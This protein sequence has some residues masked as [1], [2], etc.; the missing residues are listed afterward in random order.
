MIGPT[1]KF[2]VEFA[3]L[4]ARWAVWAEAE[5]TGCEGVA[6]TAPS[7]SPHSARHLEALARTEY[8]L[9]GEFRVA[10]D[11][12]R[13]GE[14]QL[15]ARKGRML[16][17]LL[18]VER[19]RFVPID[20]IVAALWGDSPPAKAPQN[21]ASLVSRLRSVLGPRTIHG[22]RGGY[23]LDPADA[24]VDV[25]RAAALVDEADARLAA[26]QASLAYSAADAALGLLAAGPL[27]ADEPDALWA[28]EARREVERLG[29][30]ARRA[31]WRAALEL[32]DHQEALD[33][34]G[35]GTV[36]DPLDEEAHRA[37]MLAHHRAGEPGAALAAYSRLRETL[38]EELG[39]DPGPETE[40]LYLDILRGERERPALEVTARSAMPPEP[41]EPGFVGRDD[42]LAE[43][44]GAWEGAAR[45]QPGLWLAAGEAGIGKT[46]LA[47]E[48]AR[49]VEATGGLLAHARC[50][51]AERSL[52]LQPILDAIGTLAGALPPDVLRTAAEGSAGTLGELVP[53]V[54]RI[55]R[56]LHYE[57]GAPELERRRSFE[58]VASLLQRLARR[59]PVLLLL[60]DLH[61]AG[62]STLEALH[63]LFR[64]MAT[65]RFLA[66]ATVRAEESGEVLGQLGEL[67]RVI[68]LG[69]LTETAV[70]ELARAM[71]APGMAA[72]VARMTGGHTLYAVEALRAVVEA[73]AGERLPRVPE[74]LRA[75][76]LTRVRRAGP[77]VEEL[78]RAAAV[79]GSAF[80]VEVVAGLLG[81]PLEDAV[82]RAEH[83]L[84]ARLVV[85]AGRVYEFANDLV[86]EVLYET[87]PA[88]TRLVRHRRAIALVANP[89]AVG[90][91]AAAAGD[92]ATAMRSWEEAAARATAAFANRDAERLLSEALGSAAHAD[93]PLAEARIRLARARVRWQLA[94]HDGAHGDQAV[95]LEL[96]RALPDPRLEA[97]ALEQL[98]WTAWFVRDAKGAEELAER[99]A[100]MAERA[101][102]GPYARPG[103]LV[104]AGRVRHWRG[105]L[106]G[107][108]EAV[109]AALELGPDP[110][111]APL[112]RYAL[113]AIL[114]HAD[115]YAEAQRVLDEATREFERQGQLR[116]LLSALFFDALALM[117]L[118][119]LAG[120]LRRLER[121]RGL[122]DRYELAYYRPR[123]ATTMAAVWWELGDLGRAGDLVAQALEDADRAVE[124]LS[125][126]QQHERAHALM[127]AAE[128]ALRSGDEAGAASRLNEAAPL[129][130]RGLPF[131]SR[132]G[133]RM[134]ELG[135]RLNGSRAEELL[136]LACARPHPKY[137]AL[138]LAHL[139]RREEAAELARGLR[140][141]LLLAQVAPP[142]E[143]E[144]ATGRIAARLP[145][146]LKGMFARARARAEGATGTRQQGV[147]R[148]H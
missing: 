64:R 84:A 95:A 66:V 125:A 37:V 72:P 120:A 1:G 146:E 78:L 147:R 116:S 92:W 11:G 49:L 20:R 17:K 87:T 145:G 128:V 38:V 59:Q 45:G 77:E 30:R 22:G 3:E 57:R 139:G 104:L 19:G 79:I 13:L 148:P 86:R 106:A 107:A 118:G 113:G 110:E 119:D 69:P 127:A 29:R 51:E 130:G 68:E 144:A 132:W 141:D 44:S 131:E 52:F 112:A 50:Y 40:A 18:V 35:A 36:A 33:I 91:H 55:L 71:G 2:L 121:K 81:A 61:Q 83:A 48:L 75:A 134:A 100:E 76:V 53:E 60:D 103:G 12:N 109:R 122:L 62:A 99:A 123:T 117:A 101:A 39:A 65:D 85:E 42:E 89:E 138:A 97:A 26:G 136:E 24:L 143:A 46:R 14:H 105:D 70:G 6:L 31:A 56:P 15:A 4:V 135:A 140:S 80:D 96:A 126:T 108:E 21:V 23:R 8:R 74:S 115:R 43:L 10:R 27:L 54:A 28:E 142:P 88:P 98:G 90:A 94:D 16:L 137:R 114:Q 34:A 111:T 102:S 124:P 7:A 58:A 5:V 9:L 47:L 129:L 25:D 63:F 32:G 67:A 73:G 93:D 82:R 41:G 133:L